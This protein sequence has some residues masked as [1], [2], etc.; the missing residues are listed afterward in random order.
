MLLRRFQFVNYLPL[1][2]LK[3]Q[4]QVKETIHVCIWNCHYM[5]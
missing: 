4:A 2:A 5:M 1:G 3:A